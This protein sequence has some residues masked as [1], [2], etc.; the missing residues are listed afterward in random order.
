M[1]S[2]TPF[3]SHPVAR[4]QPWRRAAGIWLLVVWMLAIGLGPLLARMHQI[5]HP[6]QPVAVQ[7]Q[8]AGQGVGLARSESLQPQSSLAPPP[9]S[10][11]HALGAMFAHH[12]SLDCQALDQ[13]AHA[14][15]PG[16]VAMLWLSAALPLF[17]APPLLPWVL[18]ERPWGW[19][20]RGPPASFI[21]AAG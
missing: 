18:L 9:G 17:L 7:L 16:T 15:A 11:A 1:S 19:T 21:A 4:T 8:Q 10:W 3:T 2:T 12:H 20:A 5:V 14:Q 13:L 6:A